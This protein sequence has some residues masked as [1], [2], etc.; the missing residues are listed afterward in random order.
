MKS[1]PS[2]RRTP[3]LSVVRLENRNLPASTITVMPGANG[4]GSL[5][6][7][8]FDTT[9]GVIAAVDGDGNPG[10]LSTGALAA[11]GA[12]TSISVSASNGI[13]FNDLGGTVTLQTGPGN[14]VTFDAGGGRISI[15]NK[16]NTLVTSGASVIFTA[17]MNLGAMNFNTGGGDVTL[18]AGL[19][20]SAIVGP[21]NIQA[22]K[23]NI[24][25]QSTNPAGGSISHFGT[26][27]GQSITFAATG[28][29]FADELHGTN[30]SLTSTAGSVN[31]TFVEPVQ[32][33]GL[34]SISAAQGIDLHTGATSVQASNGT[35]G[36]VVIIQDAT[37]AVPLTTAGT[38]VR[39]QAPSRF[40]Q[41]INFSQTS[42]TVAAGSPVLGG[43]NSA[44]GLTATDLNILG[45]VNSSGGGVSLESP[46][47]GWPIDL[48]T[49]TPGAVGLTLAELNNISTGALYF[50]QDPEGLIT[51][52][53]PIVAPAG[54]NTVWLRS[55]AGV[56]E[57]TGGSLTVPNLRLETS[58]P[59][60]M[61]SANNVRVLAAATTGGL[62][63]ANGTNPLT[64]GTVDG[65]VGVSTSGF[66]LGIT[67][68]SLDVQQ[69]VN[70][71]A[72]GVTFQPYSPAAGVD[73]GGGDAAGTLGLS[74]AELGRVTAGVL[75]VVSG[76]PITVSS[77]IARHAGYGVMDLWTPRGVTQTAALSVAN[78][79]LRLTGG[80]ATVAL[81]N[82][83]NDVDTLSAL[84]G[85]APA[86]SFRDVNGFAIGNGP[87]VSGISDPS[88][89]VILTAGGAITD[90]NGAAVN[91]FAGSLAV[92]AT[93]GVDIDTQV[94][95]LSVALTENGAITLTQSGPT[96][97]TVTGLTAGNGTITLDG[98]TFVLAG[99]VTAGSVV[100]AGATLAG[101]GTVAAPV[102]VN[103]GGR[104]APGTGAGV[105]GTG[106]LQFAAGV[107]FAVD[108][109]SPYDAAGFDYDRVNVT[110]TVN[111]NAATLTFAG[112]SVAS[113]AGQVLTLIRNDGTDPVLGTF[114]GLPAGSTVVVA[115]FA[116]TISYTGGDGNDVTLTTM[117]PSPAV[118]QSVVIDNGTAQ[119]SQVRS[120]TVT[121]NRPVGFT[122]L[123]PAA[124]QLARSGPGTTGNVT[125]GVDL[126][127]SNATQTIARLTFS[128]PLTEGP[129]SLIDGNY[130]LTVFGGQ[131][132]GGLQGGDNVST[133]FRL[134]GDIDGN[135]AVNGL[136]L[137]AF[138][139]AFGSVSADT[140]FVPFLD[141]D[142]D[143]AINGRD[144]T[145][146][147]NRFGIILP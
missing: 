142:G 35:A 112:G 18:T 58:G 127:G 106:D 39:S 59:V 44:I 97:A 120:I 107:T 81:A 29:V 86:I 31:S 51:I 64:I 119:R 61:R 48:G 135:K 24:L 126:S 40:V 33:T 96:A 15:V 83:G 7:F 54:C 145:Q 141:F 114:A 4:S 99:N 6:G 79:S 45:A 87:G 38:G 2:R 146:F 82:A 71:G 72:G 92:S 129:N 28:N 1:K 139:N 43:P 125:L 147:R 68:D 41:L 77:A 66:S 80:S 138:R 100:V 113:P 36:D 21:S 122:G 95:T 74:D 140:A 131:V 17:G 11:V 136:D 47:P 94:N 37:P 23:G 62:D 111:L 75:D 53:A 144:L 134:F 67:A 5:D 16:G 93:S 73:L 26:I 60:S 124:F 110:G 98:G 70:A 128:G 56:T 108:V 143:G 30:I 133:L 69:P 102:T 65:T 84:A 34:L 22:G 117:P 10:M 63:F 12:G 50:G 90:G 104:L 85:G 103:S 9:P 109:N 88:A 46:V 20:A 137:A 3:A 52:S 105:I 101:N 76:G 123:T 13:T 27:A 89:V 115:A 19:T 8:L 14:S 132:Q 78:L 25:I 91:V 57:A 118:V 121:F 32:C 130:T 42:I 49:N 55:G 116:A